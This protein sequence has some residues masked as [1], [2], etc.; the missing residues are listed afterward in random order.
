M[1]CQACNKNIERGELLSCSSCRSTY[2]FKCLNI[3][4]E[5]YTE[6]IHKVKRSWQ[7]PTCINVTRRRN[8]NT[9]VRN[10]F[11]L[12][13]EESNM[14]CEDI[15]SGLD[16]SP[17]PSYAKCEPAAVTQVPSTSAPTLSVDQFSQLFDSK[18]DKIRSALISDFKKEFKNAVE[19]LKLE[20]TQS[21][22]LIAAEQSNLKSD[23]IAANKKIESITTEKI[24]LKSEIQELTRRLCVL[25]K[26]SRS[27]NIEIQLI[28]E[29]KNE[30][31]VGIFKHLCAAIKAP[32]VESDICSIRRVAKLNSQSSRPRN[33]IVTLPSERHRDT[34]ISTFKRF[35]KSNKSEP[36]NSSHLDIPGQ[37]QNIYVNEHLSPECKAI[38]AATKKAAKEYSYTYVWVR[39]DRVYT[40]KNDQSPAVLIKNISDLTKISS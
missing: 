24:Q 36:L 3:S 29:K 37:K 32:I 15:A 28:P 16:K 30:N 11:E 6:H 18:I 7:C 13:L 5:Y 23:L 25:E 38:F 21:L 14:S 8:E 34:L 12:L 35:N 19:K 4:K 33:I 26:S 10:Q 17:V 31:L 2:D 39:N 9:P 40:R 27:R 22:D 20:F 1:K